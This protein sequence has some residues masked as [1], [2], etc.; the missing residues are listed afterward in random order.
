MLFERVFEP[1]EAPLVAAG[2]C[3]AAGVGVGVSLG[4]DAGLIALGEALEAMIS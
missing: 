4:F 2:F 1:D 3:S